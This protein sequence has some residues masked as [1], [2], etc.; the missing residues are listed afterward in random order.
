MMRKQF[1]RLN[2]MLIGLFFVLVLVSNLSV[3]KADPVDLQFYLGVIDLIGGA[4][5]SVHDSSGILPDDT[6]GLAALDGDIFALLSGT[7]GAL[8]LQFYPGVIDLI[9]GAPSSVHDVSGILPDDTL[10]LAALDGDIFALLSGVQDSTSTEMPE[11]AT[12]ALFGIGLVGMAFIRR[13]K[14]A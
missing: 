4:P 5:S 6:L 14:A 3:A 2:S 7:P 13:R 8:D 11:P 10:G 12:I 9:G 1:A